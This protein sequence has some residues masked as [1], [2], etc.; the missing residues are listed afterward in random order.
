MPANS[1]LASVTVVA[2]DSLVA[3][4]LTTAIFVLGEEKGKSLAEKFPGV[5][6]K[7][8]KERNG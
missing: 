1:G 4:A 5:K 7:I 3:D 8:I 6:I 2:D